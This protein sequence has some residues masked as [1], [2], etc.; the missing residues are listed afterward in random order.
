MKY[1]D[2]NSI[3]QGD[4]R[5]AFVSAVVYVHNEQRCVADCVKRLSCLLSESFESSELIFADDASTDKSAQTIKEAAQKADCAVSIVSMSYH[6]GLDLALE[7]GADLAVGDF[8]FEL[9]SPE[10]P[11]SENCL[12]ELYDKACKGFDIVSLAPK[13]ANSLS[14]ALY[15]TFFNRYAKSQYKLR[16]EYCRIVSRRA[17]NRIKSMTKIIPYRK[18]IF[19]NCGLKQDVITVDCAFRSHIQTKQQSRDRMNT[20]IDSVI[21]FTNFA[22]QTSIALSLFMMIVTAAIGIYAVVIKIKGIPVAGWTSTVLFISLAFFALFA[23]LTAI[24]K[25]LSIIL[26]LV[27]SRLHYVT[28]S[29]EKIR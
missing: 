15:Y 17:L 10:M 7:A 28:E 22:F 26:N 29:I 12:I 13:K 19:A 14:S 20:A 23:I 24:I 18:A 6:Q 4:K 21:L 1:S 5:K 27:Y 2:E 25:Y 11:Y 16:S 8:V 3:S 9:E